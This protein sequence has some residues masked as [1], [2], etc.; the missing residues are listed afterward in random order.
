MSVIQTIKF[1]SETVIGQPIKIPF[2][3]TDRSS[4][5]E[6]KSPGDNIIIKPITVRTWLKLKPLLIQVEKDDLDTI[7]AKKGVDFDSDIS[8]ILFKYDNLLFEIVCIGIH[9]KKG[10]MPDWFKDTLKDNSTWEDIYILLNA[11][12]FRLLVNPFFNSIILVKSVSPIGE[13]EIIA[14]QKN[15]ETW[16]SKVD[17]CSSPSATK[18]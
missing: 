12:L 1:E 5:P 3:F 4:I 6:G 14:L 18:R 8:D 16:T 10:S 2:E 13:A 9:N 17:S 15:S 11:V 7:V